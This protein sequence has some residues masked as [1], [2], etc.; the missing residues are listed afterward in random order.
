[1]GL[2]L[3]WRIYGEITGESFEKISGEVPG[4]IPQEITRIIPEISK[5]PVQ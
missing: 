3:S 4:S 5:E 1:M 2:K